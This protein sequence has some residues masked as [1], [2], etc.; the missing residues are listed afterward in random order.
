MASEAFFPALVKKIQFLHTESKM[1][2]K[3]EE[4]K[5]LCG[6]ILI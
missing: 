6:A 3:K 1:K 5:G 2:K 4:E